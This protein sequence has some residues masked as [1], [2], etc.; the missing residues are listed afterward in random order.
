MNILT[1]QDFFLGIIYLVIIYAIAYRLKSQQQK[2]G[3]DSKYFIG[4][5]T[6]KLIGVIAFCLIYGLYYGGGHCRLFSKH[7][8]SH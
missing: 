2:K 3:L 8:C 1:V 7:N 6:A 5:L 4:G